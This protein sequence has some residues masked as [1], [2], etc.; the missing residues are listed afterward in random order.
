[1]S[2]FSV[3][4]EE[5]KKKLS[6]GLTKTEIALLEK[7]FEDPFFREK[8]DDPII[9]RTLSDKFEDPFFRKQFFDDPIIAFEKLEKSS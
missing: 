4:I 9:A 8:F 1:M 5:L 6:D 7:T 2:R 3:T